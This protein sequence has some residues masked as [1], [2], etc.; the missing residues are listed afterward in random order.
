MF[1]KSIVSSA[2]ILPTTSDCGTCRRQRRPLLRQNSPGRKPESQDS[3]KAAPLPPPPPPP[4]T[5]L[6]YKLG[7]AAPNVRSALAPIPPPSSTPTFWSASALPRLRSRPWP[8]R[9]VPVALPAQSSR[10]TPPHAMVRRWRGPRRGLRHRVASLLLLRAPR[11]SRR[12]RKYR[13]HSRRRH[14]CRRLDRCARLYDHRPTRAPCTFRRRRLRSLP[15]PAEL[16]RSSPP[17]PAARRTHIRHRAASSRHAR[18][19]TRARS[20]LRSRSRS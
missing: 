2:G 16:P 7:W 5:P 3:V 9:S 6:A 19:C 8:V 15:V 10:D 20:Q 11:R 4:S 18:T 12:S 14:R 1:S 17:F 13:S